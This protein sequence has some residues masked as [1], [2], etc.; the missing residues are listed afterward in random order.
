ME[1]PEVTRLPRLFMTCVGC[2]TFEMP[3]VIK[4]MRGAEGQR[5]QVKEILKLL[6]LWEINPP[7]FWRV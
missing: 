3:S 7:Y 5:G 2:E 6:G 4:L 1:D